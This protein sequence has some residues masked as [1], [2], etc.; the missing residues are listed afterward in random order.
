MALGLDQ[1][2][3]D[4]LAHQGQ[5]EELV[6]L[7]GRGAG[8]TGLGPALGDQR[9]GQAAVGAGGLRGQ[10]AADV[11]GRSLGAARGGGG[12]LRR[13]LHVALD[14]AAAGTGARARCAGRPR[15]RWP[16]GGR[17]ARRGPCRW[18]RCATAVGAGGRSGLGRRGWR[19]LRRRGP[20]P[21]C[22]RRRG[23]ALAR[24]PGRAGAGAGAGLAAGGSDSR[25]LLASRASARA[26]VMSSPALPMIAMGAPTG[27][28]APSATSSL[29]STPSSNDSKSMV[30]LSVSTSAHEFTGGDL[31]AL[32][33]L[34]LAEDALLHGV[35]ELRHFQELSHSGFLAGLTGCRRRVPVRCR[36]QGRRPGGAAELLEVEDLL[37]ELGGLLGIGA[38]R[39]LD[40]AVVGRGDVQAG[41]PLDRVVEIVEAAALRSGRR[42]RRPRR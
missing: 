27:T 3:G 8:G 25:A 5:R 6:L 12:T 30:A 24:A 26:A 41:E 33:L 15:D 2:A 22:R 29:S 39:G 11:G 38:D 36:R 37:D 19:R 9:V 10:R 28:V 42:S 32:L 35:G 40:L 4:G 31:V 17:A 1:P 21:G 16:G 13:R 23:C 20:A 7:A 18:R 34:P 14:D